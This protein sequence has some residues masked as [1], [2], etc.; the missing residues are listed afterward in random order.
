MPYTFAPFL[1]ASY[2]AWDRLKDYMISVG[3]KGVAGRGDGRGSLVFLIFIRAFH[4]RHT[5]GGGLLGP[6]PSGAVIACQL[7]NLK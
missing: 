6:Y 4:H 2:G 1:F 7:L 5:G 3:Q